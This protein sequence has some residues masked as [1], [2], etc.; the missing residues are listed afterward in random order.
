[1]GRKLKNNNI[2]VIGKI[3]TL[4]KLNNAPIVREPPPEPP[5]KTTRDIKPL[6]DSPEPTE[7]I[8]CRHIAMGGSPV[9]WCRTENYDWYEFS[10]WI[11][12]DPKRRQKYY[13]A[14][15]AQNEWAAI[16]ILKDLRD[17]KDYDLRKILYDDGSVKP[18]S[19]WPL[20]VAKAIE[21]FE[22]VERQD[23][24]MIKSIVT[25][26]K[27]KAIEML[28]KNLGILAEKVIVSRGPQAAADSF[29]DNFF[30]L[31]KPAFPEQEPE[32]NGTPEEILGREEE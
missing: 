16:T 24:A 1:M 9:E 8:I 3:P 2:I 21:S 28:M 11:N 12:H 22:V 30:G 31:N 6:Y 4:D 18:V 15:L 20:S 17:M 10:T 7:E 26:K 19:E 27:L 25:T 29:I 13:E 23:G 32:K 5:P 14:Y